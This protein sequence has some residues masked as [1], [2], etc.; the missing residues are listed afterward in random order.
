VT[1]H[2][3]TAGELARYLAVDRSWVYENAARLGARRL[4]S[5]PKARLRFSIQEVD[6]A[7]RM[8]PEGGAAAVLPCSNGRGTPEREPGIA[9]ALRRRRSSAPRSASVQLLPIRGQRG[10][11]V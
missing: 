4:G 3:A 5:G 11:R 9:P 7:L 10:E 1:E 2:L 6:T 8:A